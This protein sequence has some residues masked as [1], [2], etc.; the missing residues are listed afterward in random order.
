MHTVHSLSLLIIH[1]LILLAVRY[2][3]HP[4]DKNI[5]SNHQTSEIVDKHNLG[6]DITTCSHFD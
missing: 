4:I 2:S 5:E 6:T 3:K 1:S